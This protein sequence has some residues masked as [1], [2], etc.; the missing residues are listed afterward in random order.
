MHLGPAP[1][2][3]PCTQ[4]DGHG[5]IETAASL[6]LFYKVL[7]VPGS[8][9]NPENRARKPEASIW[10]SNDPVFLFQAS[11]RT[12]WGTSNSSAKQKETSSPTSCSLRINL[13]TLNLDIPIETLCQWAQDWKTFPE[14]FEGWS[15]LGRTTLLP[16]FAGICTRWSKPGPSPQGSCHQHQAWA[17]CPEP[18]Q[19][20]FILLVNAP[21]YTPLWF[22][23]CKN[24]TKYNK[25]Y[26]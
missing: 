11:F 13:Q 8:S 1:S 25:N 5:A 26:L 20:R 2:C 22:R 18:C 16:P 3:A 12:G 23:Y 7:P 15:M 17:P 4:P 14:P 24:T 19:R 10:D 21:H 9:V 6:D